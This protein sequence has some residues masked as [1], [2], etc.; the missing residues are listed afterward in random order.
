[1]RITGAS[2]LL[3]RHP[4]AL[5]G[6]FI[7]AVFISYLLLVAIFSH[8]GYPLL[9]MTTVPVG[10]GGGLFGLWLLNAVRR[11]PVAAGP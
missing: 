1:M 10:I 5:K 3:K 11:Q 2:D 4:Y 7:V 8:W 9:V 6:N